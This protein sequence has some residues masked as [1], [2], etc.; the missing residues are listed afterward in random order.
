MKY[1]IETEKDNKKFGY[2]NFY[3]RA[4]NIKAELEISKDRLV[5]A[6]WRGIVGIGYDHDSIDTAVKQACDDLIKDIYNIIKFF[7]EKDDSRS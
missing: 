4:K 7:E 6:K 3:M 2:V 1:I 5:L